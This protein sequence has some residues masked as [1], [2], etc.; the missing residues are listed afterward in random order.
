[1]KKVLLTTALLSLSFA[2]FSQEIKHETGV[3]NIEVPVR[4]YHGNAFVDDLALDDFEVYENGA[5][6]KLEAVYLIKKK[7]IE[8]EE[9]EKK[10]EPN[11]SR[12]FYLFFEITEYS[13]RIDD[14]LRYFMDNVLL[15]GDAL[16]IVTPLKTYEMNPQALKV[17]GKEE[18]VKDLRGLLRKDAMTAGS[19]YR[20]A[21]RELTRITRALASALPGGQAAG[22]DQFSASEYAEMEGDVKLDMLMTLYKGT[23]TQLEGMRYIDQAKLLGFA[24]SLRNKEGQK[25]VFL[26]YQREFV[27]Q[28]DPRILS[29]SIGML[30]NQSHISQD[31]SHLFQSFK[32]EVSFDVDKVKKAYADASTSIQ[33]MFFTKPAEH[34]PGLRFEEHSEDIYS[35]FREMSAATG[36]ITESS[37]NPS[38]LFK[39]AVE[40]SENYYLLYYTPKDAERDWKFRKIE[41][42][43]KNRSYR[44]LHRSGYF[45]R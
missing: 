37:S 19:E 35:A 36:G 18:I 39:R 40:S 6:Q 14:A 9:G 38:S 44:I 34:I 27:P 3:V 42:K 32:R 25:V 29:A 13:P 21:L 1:M 22:Q 24:E 20:N 4:V 26:F 45:A 30:Q 15:P 17:R 5:L 41:V 33:F 43:V 12:L 8:K 31:L 7:N 11:T 16:F 2:L 10:Y 23:L 28:I